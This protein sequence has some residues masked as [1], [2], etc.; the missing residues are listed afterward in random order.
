MDIRSRPFETG[1]FWGWICTGGRKLYPTA[2]GGPPV[3][4]E[5]G[6]CAMVGDILGV[7]LEFKGS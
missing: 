5:Y 2:P 1:K 6:S 3:A 7:L 4:R